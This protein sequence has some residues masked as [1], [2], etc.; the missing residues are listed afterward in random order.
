MFLQVRVDGI[1][2]GILVPRARTF[3]KLQQMGAFLQE[4]EVLFF[5]EVKGNVFFEERKIMNRYFV[6]NRNMNIHITEWGDKK[7][8]VIFCL[9]GLGGLV[10]PLQK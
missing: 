10:F 3:F 5:I 1:A 7:N 6:N 8:P 4:G 9:H 2:A